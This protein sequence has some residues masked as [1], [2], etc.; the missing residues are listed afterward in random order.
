VAGASGFLGSHLCQS[1]KNKNIDCIGFSRKCGAMVDYIVDDYKELISSYDKNNILINL[2]GD[3]ANMDVNEQKVIFELSN[4]YKS[5]MIFISSSMVYGPYSDDK[6]SEKMTL[7]VSNDYAK[8][9][10]LSEKVI[11]NNK[12]LILRLASI[13]G[14]GM[15]KNKLFNSIYN[16][17]NNEGSH[18]KIRNMNVI[19]DYLYIDDFCDA[20]N[21][22]LE[23]PLKNTII[24]LGSGIGI[25]SIKLVEVICK[26]LNKDFSKL[27]I[28]SKEDTPI[29]SILNTDL[30]EKEYNWTSNINIENGILKWIKNSRKK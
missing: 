17:I 26:N 30:F 2:A 27:K 10:A 14:Q 12:G 23:K 5:N 11:L 28:S 20:M 21:S 16:Q 6:F 22:V 8:S 3:N 15:E 7:D 24:N 25:K 29:K 1:F 13:Y 4:V 9:K 19:K 18:L